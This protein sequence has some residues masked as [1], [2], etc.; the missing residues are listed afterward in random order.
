MNQNNIRKPL[1]KKATFAIQC[2]LQNNN[3]FLVSWIPEEYAIKGKTLK[4]QD[5][6]SKK[7]E[8]GWV[9]LD[10]GARKPYDF[11]I[12]GSQDH[13]GWREVTDI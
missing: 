6:A 11:I 8:N 4:L 1:S 3:R 7:W 12:E 2:R 9:V 13:R 5:R 10:T